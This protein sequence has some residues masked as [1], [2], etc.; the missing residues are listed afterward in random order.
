[1]SAMREF[2]VVACT[3]RDAE[4]KWNGFGWTEAGLGEHGIGARHLGAQPF[5]RCAALHGQSV[6]R[7]GAR[8]RGCRVGNRARLSGHQERGAGRGRGR[9]S[10]EELR[11]CAWVRCACAHGCG[12]HVRTRRRQLHHGLWLLFVLGFGT[13]ANRG[14]AQDASI[15]QQTALSHRTV[16][17]TV[18]RARIDC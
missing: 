4:W 8:G 12:T 17:C 5:K 13:Q 2:R 15:V 6:V 9:A 1:M 3:E 10:A 16:S 14:S 7:C 18:P 11:V